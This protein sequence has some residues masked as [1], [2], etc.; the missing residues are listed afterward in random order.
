VSG[1]L[2]L[3]VVDAHGIVAVA[4]GAGLAACGLSGTELAGREAAFALGRHEPLVRAVRSALDGTAGEI[5]LAVDG[6]HFNVRYEPRGGGAGSPSGALLI[7]DTNL[8]APVPEAIR[9]AEARCRRSEARLREA[10]RI[11]HVGSWE[12]DVASNRIEWTEEMYRIY[13]MTPADFPGT[14][15]AFLSH[16]LDDDREY[17]RTVVFDAYR[18]LQPFVYDH[19]VVRPDGSVRMLH[20]RGEVFTDDGG[21]VTR[22]AGACWDI[23]DLWQRSQECERSASLLRAS[24]ESTADGLLVIDRQG[25][26]VAHNERLLTLWQ[27]PATQLSG[28]TFETLLEVVHD[29]LVNGD[30]CLRRVREMAAHPEAESFDSLQFKD[31]RFFERYSRPQRIGDDVIGRVWSY[32]DVTERE[33]LLRNTLFLAD[34]SRLFVSLDVEKALSA[35]ASLVLCHFGDACAVDLVKDGEMRR[36]VSECR[37]P[38]RAIPPE[39]P[40]AL[41]SGNPSIYKIGWRSYLSVPLSDH[42]E[43]LGA[44]TFSARDE[45][46][47]NENDLAVAIELGQRAELALAISQ[48]YKR[49]TDALTARDDFLSVASHEIRGPVT[50]IH[51]AVQGLLKS[52]HGSA[53]VSL[54][55]IIEREDRRIR[56]FI[57]ELIDLARIR[58]QQFH[59]VLGPVDLVAVTR[60][61]IARMTADATR[62]GSTLSITTPAEL[63][64][65]WD[66]D[67]LAQVVANLLSNALKFGLAKPI[68]VRVERLGDMARLTVQDRGMGVPAEAQDRVFSLFE[69]AVSPRHYGGL[70]LGLYIVRT[71]VDALGGT[72][73]LESASGHGTTVTVDIPIARAA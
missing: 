63:C 56:R 26:L 19:R 6:A 47:Y 20:T 17:T 34:A 21:K 64:G 29:Q 18:T 44:L 32:R 51:L 2:I 53:A 52:P 10:Q 16:V 55:S 45:R 36:L 4:E 46:S 41:W 1:G 72:V 3:I 69:R 37:E 49:M 73:A 57:D 60:E 30:A 40:R 54:L 13:G 28:K 71:I 8:S 59:F 62:S 23:T 22:M 58:S 43:S 70:G 9:Q 68:D 15:E 25:Q 14:Y 66:R 65:T 31:G 33:R 38:S 27:L 67:R 7:A 5:T 24:F 11:A 48:S 35:L 39:I 50:S 42:G 12:W 61:V